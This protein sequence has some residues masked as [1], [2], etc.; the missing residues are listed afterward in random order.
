MLSLKRALVMGRQVARRC[1]QFVHSVQHEVALLNVA[2]VEGACAAWIVLT[3]LR[4]LSTCQQAATASQPAPAE[5]LALLWTVAKD[6]LYELGDRSKLLPP[7]PPS[8]SA[9]HPSCNPRFQVGFF[10]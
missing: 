9:R 4:V 1:L 5:Y 2:C 7:S 8:P 6:K 10:I 3:C